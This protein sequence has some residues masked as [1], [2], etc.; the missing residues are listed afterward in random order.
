[1]RNFIKGDPSVIVKKEKKVVLLCGIL[2][3]FVAS[4]VAYP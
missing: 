2:C 1:M 3:P 4:F